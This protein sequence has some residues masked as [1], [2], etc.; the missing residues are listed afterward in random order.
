MKLRST[1]TADGSPNAARRRLQLNLETITRPKERLCAISSPFLLFPA[2]MMTAMMMRGRRGED[3]DDWLGGGGASLDYEAS[4]Q[5]VDEL[6]A[7]VLLLAVITPSTDNTISLPT[8]SYCKNI[9]SVPVLPVGSSGRQTK[10]SGY[11]EGLKQPY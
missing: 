9:I 3:G 11:E 4:Q 1:D 2:M 5:E 7:K 6:A 10:L 8:L